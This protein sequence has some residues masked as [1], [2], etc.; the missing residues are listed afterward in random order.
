MRIFKIGLILIGWLFFMPSIVFGAERSGIQISP[1]TY[2]FDIRPGESQEAKITVKNLN[3]EALNYVIETENFVEASDEGAPS[4][5]GLPEVKGVTTLADWFS[6]LNNDKEGIIEPGKEKEIS[7]KITIPEGAEPG[8]H[9]AAIFAKQIKKNAVGQTELGIASRVGTLILVSV[10]GNVTKTAEITEFKA[11]K[12][13]WKG[14]VDLSM[15]VKNTGTVHYDSEAKVVFK[16]IIGASSEADLGTHTL[17]P[18]NIRNYDGK[19]AKKYPFGFY[20]LTATASDGDQQPVTVAATM[21]A[22]PLVIVIPVLLAI[23]ILVLVIRYFRKHYRYVQSKNP[24][25]PKSS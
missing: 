7:F 17:L 11:P 9:Y 19:W 3:K 2:N 20:T 18:K 6:M 16:P 10:P 15:K 25:S 12:I 13:V 21:W 23:L 14:P 1:L 8:G 22:I 24:P 4:F 5:E